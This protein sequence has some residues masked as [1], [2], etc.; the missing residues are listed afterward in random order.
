QN[1]GF[2][3]LRTG[4]YPNSLLGVFSSLRQMLL[5][6]QHYRDEQALSART[7]RGMRRPEA[8]RSLEALVPV[9]EGRQ[10]VIMQ[11]SSQREI[12][13]ALGL[14]KEFKLKAIVAGGS[15]AYLVAD[16]LKAA[17]VPVL[18]SLNFPHRTAAPSADADP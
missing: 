17:D 2:T 9:V 11:A 7:A 13:R 5:D 6:A 12:E 1:I 18:F 8:A 14:A 10:P 4:G 15:E 3:P 16:Q